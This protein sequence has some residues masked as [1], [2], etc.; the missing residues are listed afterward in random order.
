VALGAL[1]ALFI[2]RRRHGAEEVAPE[3]GL[4][5]EQAA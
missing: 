2:P 5:F 4:A 3:G 1:A